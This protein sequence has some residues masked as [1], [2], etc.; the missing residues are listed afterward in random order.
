MP[1]ETLTADPPPPHAGNGH[2]GVVV[3]GAPTVRSLLDEQQR[4]TPVERFADA[5]EA[6]VAPAQSKY[7]RDLIPLTAP[8]EGEQYAFDVDLDACSGCKACVSACHHLNG[9]EEGETW[10]WVGQLNDFGSQSGAAAATG[11]LP[12]IQHITTACHHCVD[13]G[14][15]AGCPTNAY[16]KDPVTGVVRHLDDQCFGC[17]YCTMACPYEVPQYSES[18]GIVRKCDM[19]HDRL[20]EGEAPACVQACPNQAIRISVVSVEESKRVGLEGEWLPGTPPSDFTKP[21]TVYRSKRPM[22]ATAIGADRGVVEPQ[23]AHWPLLVMLVLTQASVGGVALTAL[24]RWL[25]ADSSPWF[26]TASFAL[27][28]GMGLAGL[29]L[30]PLH[31]GRPLYAFRAILGWRHSWLSREALVFGGFAPAAIAATLLA[32]L[33][34]V[35]SAWTEPVLAWVPVPVSWLRAPT[36]L[37]AIAVGAAGVFC[38]AMIYIFTRRVLWSHAMTFLKFG[39]TP[40]TLGGSATLATWCVTQAVRDQAVGVVGPM[41]ALLVATASVIKLLQDAWLMLWLVKPDHP[42]AMSAGLMVGPMRVQT[43]LR[44]ACSALGGLVLT[45]GAATIGG[46]PGATLACMA[47]AAVF[48]GEIAE[49]YLYFSA[50]VP[51]RMPG[52]IKS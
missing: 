28:T 22:S 51:L 29:G 9:L 39:L 15:L 48:A 31:L 14:C 11:A 21:T 7:Y 18:K 38:S 20:A 26:E 33:P 37:S 43:A 49:R 46:V 4:M 12:I 44:F 6:G 23:H 42:L 2:S 45:L 24:A 27:A 13:P 5:H 17:Q 36:E 3:N 50:V 34:L 52:G 30:A 1:P 10:R 35:P 8:G 32:A 25:A 40:L 41:L 19:C 16:E 47:L